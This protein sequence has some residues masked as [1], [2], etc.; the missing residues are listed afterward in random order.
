MKQYC[1]A[2]KFKIQSRPSFLCK[3]RGPTHQLEIFSAGKFIKESN[4]TCTFWCLHFERHIIF[5]VWRVKLT[6]DWDETSPNAELSQLPKK[7][8]M[9]VSIKIGY[10]QVTPP[11]SISQPVHSTFRISSNLSPQ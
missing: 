7:H 2:W 9:L 11:V 6:R 8:L 3:G 10:K 1:K 5:H 4:N